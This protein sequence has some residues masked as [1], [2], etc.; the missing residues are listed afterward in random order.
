[1][2][3]IGVKDL[4]AF[5]IVTDSELGVEYGDPFKVAKTISISVNP[6]VQDASLYADDSLVEFYSA[7]TSYDVSINVDDLTAET[8]GKLLGYEPDENGILRCRGDSMPS[9]FSRLHI[10]QTVLRCP[11]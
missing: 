10:R 7:I 11:P 8:K 2:A 5:P 1:M 6:Q 9:A 3:R 4:Y